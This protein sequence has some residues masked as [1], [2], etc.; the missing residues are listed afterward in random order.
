MKKL[1]I[2][3]GLVFAVAAAVQAQD[4]YGTD[5]KNMPMEGN[6]TQGSQ[7]APTAS[8]EGTIKALEPGKVTLAHGPVSALKWPAMT[9]GFSATEQQLKGTQ[10]RRQG[11][12]R[13]PN[14]WGHSDDRRH[15]QAVTD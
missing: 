9:M 7:A 3:A 10:G 4:M 5:M 11:Q 8:A 1:L 12:L 15:S 6:E 13:F 14:E 2:S